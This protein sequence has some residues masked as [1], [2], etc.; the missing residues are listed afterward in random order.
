MVKIPV[1]FLHKQRS[2]RTERKKR[3]LIA[4][5][6]QK[7]VLVNNM[8]NL[9]RKFYLLFIELCLSSDIIIYNKNTAEVL[10]RLEYVGY[11]Y[12]FKTYYERSC[13]FHNMS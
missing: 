11:N 12:V 4:T 5:D 13:T 1:D 7:L 10:Y 6:V 2:Y 3:L 9:T 8:D